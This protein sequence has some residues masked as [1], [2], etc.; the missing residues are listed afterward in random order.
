MKN[1]IT[2]CFFLL[3]QVLFAQETELQTHLKSINN[4][5]A[6]HFI[7]DTDSVINGNI[8]LIDLV[9][10]RKLKDSSDIQFIS[11]RRL[12]YKLKHKVCNTEGYDVKIV[13]TLPTKEIAEIYIKIGKFNPKDHKITYQDAAKYFV[14]YIDEQH[15]LGMEGN[16]PQHEISELKIRINN[17]ELIIPKAAYSNVYYPKLCGEKEFFLEN[18]EAYQSISGK[19]LYLYFYG[20]GV[21]TMYFGKLVFDKEKYLTKIFAGYYELGTSGSFREGFLGF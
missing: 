7:M 20:G 1:I 15:P 9:K 8:Q 16:M 6:R 21:A 18:V 2:I 14:K 5:F 19:Y 10:E 12:L 4:T 13:D 11:D 17:K 3:M